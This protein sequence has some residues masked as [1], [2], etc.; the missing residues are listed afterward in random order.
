VR[1]FLKT[2]LAGYYS[3][4]RF[5]DG[6]RSAPVLRWGFAATLVRGVLDS[7]LLYVPAALRG[8]RPWPGSF[9]PVLPNEHYF[10]HLI[11][12]APLFLLFSWLWQGSVAYAVVRLARRTCDFDRVL[13]IGGMAA[14]VVGAFLAVFDPL[15]ILA[16]LRSQVAL[17]LVHFGFALWAFVLMVVGLRRL[18]DV[19]VWLGVVI[20][21]ATAVVGYP[22]NILVMRA[23][24]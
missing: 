22:F 8:A 2:W 1:E 19:P 17:G 9:I 18:L 16:G 6:L 24:F 20:G 3:P 21:I 7:L 5:A 15:W 4:A 12:L 14:L 23:P 10:A 13:G 11:W